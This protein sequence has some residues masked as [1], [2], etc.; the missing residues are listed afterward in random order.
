MTEQFPNRAYF[1]CADARTGSS[2]L[3][4]T[5]RLTEVAGKPFEYFG[6]AEIDKPWLR[7]ELRVPESVPFTGFRDWRDYIVKA[8]SELGGTFAATVHWFQWSHAISTFRDET[9]PQISDTAV[10]RAYFPQLRLVW[11]R[12]ENI[13]AQAISHYVAITTNVWSR[14][15][16]YTPPGG[17]TDH[18]APYDFD[19]IDWQVKSALVAD[20]GWRKTLADAR[21]ITLEISYEQISADLEGTVR[22][23]LERVGIALGDKSVPPP[24][25][26][27]Q[28]SD[29]S[30]DLERRYREER[31]TRGMGPVGD[32]AALG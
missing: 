15:H 23:V 5:L 19:K 20:I 4:A 1:I 8:G 9:A 21:D 32:E 16:G 12:R 11:L 6:E 13:V 2:L 7:E 27:K 3:A 29:W 24:I 10:L 22:R 18:L 14:R 30:R 17:R 28:A 31:A 26:Q 25:L